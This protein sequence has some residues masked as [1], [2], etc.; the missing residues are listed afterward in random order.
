[1]LL[2]PFL[3]ELREVRT[4]LIETVVFVACDTRPGGQT[5]L[6]PS[7]NGGNVEYVREVISDPGS[8]VVLV[9]NSVYPDLRSQESEFIFSGCCLELEENLSETV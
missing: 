7:M 4:A 1:M 8:S 5:V 9:G 6:I 3:C 2:E